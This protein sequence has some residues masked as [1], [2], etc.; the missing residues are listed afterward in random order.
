MKETASRRELV[1]AFV[2]PLGVDREMINEALRVALCTVDYSLIQIRA[3][4]MI[5]F[6]SESASLPQINDFLERKQR[7]MDGGDVLRRRFSDFFDDASRGDAV[8]LACLTAIRRERLS[9][10]ATV[11][12]PKPDL[13]DLDAN[14]EKEI[15]K[16]RSSTPLDKTA[17][18]IDS[19]KHP[20]EIELLK[21]VYGPAFI[22]VGVH[23]PLE[24][25]R[26]F[27]LAEAKAANEEN[28]VLLADK[29]LKRDET[30]EDANGNAVH[31]GQDVSDAFYATDF[32]LDSSLEKSLVV[33]QLTRLIELV[34]GNPFLT[35]TRTELGMFLARAAQVRSNSLA[36][37]VGAAIVREDGS[38]V[39]IGTNEVARPISGGQYWADDDHVYS[40]RDYVYQL[41]DTSDQF[42]EEMVEDLLK[43][44]D[45]A[46]ALANAYSVNEN[47]ESD[48][49]AKAK[50]RRD[51]RMETLYNDENSPL[52]KALL[53]DNIDYVRAVHA[54]AAS[55]IDSAR[56]GNNTANTSMYATTFPCHECARH[57]VAAGIK[58]VVYL[59]PYQ[60]SAVRKLFKD[61]IEIDPKQPDARKVQFK[62]FVG[63][64]PTRYLEFFAMQRGRK[65]KRGFVKHYALRKDPPHL[66]YYTPTAKASTFNEGLELVPFLQFLESTQRVSDD[67]THSIPSK[68]NAP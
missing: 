52:R 53:R 11:D 42:R 32:I 51:L 50:A 54:E 36:R 26:R 24:T 37:Q 56:H 23:A 14:N 47:G 18:L 9:L 48:D 44:L 65:D 34:F 35:P 49:P 20:D 45:D 29:L 64:A 15:E 22:S 66:P 6:F 61:S 68:E 41:Q 46:G 17:F 13:T 5:E 40:G 60:K 7:L 1:F 8:A 10:N 55:I 16:A 30:G 63:V 2:A 67:A 59:A 33:K 4:S 3:S 57:I 21:R 12:L 39:A 43:K 38:V 58:E 62:T 27:L 19:L 25:R 28:A 31:L